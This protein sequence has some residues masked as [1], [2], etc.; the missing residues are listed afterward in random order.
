MLN[1]EGLLGVTM[2]LNDL[3]PFATAPHMLVDPPLAKLMSRLVVL[4][5]LPT[6]GAVPPI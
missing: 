2:V 1:I 4:R 6:T 5:D 3:G